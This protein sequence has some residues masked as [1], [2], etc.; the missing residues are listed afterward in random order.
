VKNNKRGMG[1]YD[2]REWLELRFR[3][4]QK[5]GRKCM[6]CGTENGEMHVDHIKPISKHPQLSLSESNLQVLCR[7]CNLGK[8]NLSDTSFRTK[9]KNAERTNPYVRWARVS[10][11]LQ[12]RIRKCEITGN[13]LGQSIQLKRY[14]KIQKRMTK[15]QSLH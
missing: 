2:S 6:A 7:A 9:I 3:I 8:S 13:R 15:I 4:I 12:R 14:L 10:A 5:F 1:F 11:L